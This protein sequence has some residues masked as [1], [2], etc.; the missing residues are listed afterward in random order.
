MSSNSHQRALRWGQVGCAAVGT[1]FLVFDTGPGWVIP[2]IWMAAA[3]IIGAL[4]IVADLVVA[5]AA[6]HLIVS[7]VGRRE[8]AAK[9]G[10][11][12]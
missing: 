3:T 2:Q 9:I 4:S 10:P 5:A 6:A 7:E 12:D 1:A 11:S 8:A